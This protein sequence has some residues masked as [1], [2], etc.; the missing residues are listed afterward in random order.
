M[1]MYHFSSNIAG[2]CNTVIAATLFH[3]ILYWVEKNKSFADMKKDGQCW[4]YHS[5]NQ[6]KKRFTCFSIRQIEHSLKILEKKELIIGTDKYTNEPE[7][8]IFKTTKWY[9]ITEKGYDV[10]G[11]D[12]EYAIK[13]IKGNYDRKGSRL[14]FKT[15]QFY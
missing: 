13:Q 14:N 5:Y 9:T 11:G 15:A 8:G 2:E 3:H 1:A 12:K 6:F 7:A 4:M 10:L